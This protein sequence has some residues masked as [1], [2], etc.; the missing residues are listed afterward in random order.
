MP[1]VIASLQ[2]RCLREIIKRKSKE[3]ALGYCKTNERAFDLL[4]DLICKHLNQ[5]YT[6]GDRLY[7]IHTSNMAQVHIRDKVKA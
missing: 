6:R 3:D 1:V 5:R 4:F 7:K 2:R